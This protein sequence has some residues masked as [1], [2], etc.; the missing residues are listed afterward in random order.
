MS[1]LTERIPE[2]IE[3]HVHLHLPGLMELLTPVVAH[4]L[5]DLKELKQMSETLAGDLAVQDANVVALTSAVAT[6]GTEITTGLAANASAIAALQA[7]IAAGTPATP[8]QLA[9]LDSNNSAI[10]AA[11]TALGS[12][13][14]TLQ[15]AL[16]PA[17]VAQA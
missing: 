8:A 3:V 2:Q 7:Q 17:P 11:A 5:G 12:A 13:T 9:D 16:N 14:T 6:L 1:A 4:V 15:A 10:A